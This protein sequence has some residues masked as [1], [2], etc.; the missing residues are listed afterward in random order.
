MSFLSRHKEV[1]RALVFI[2]CYVEGLVLTK[3][4]LVEKVALKNTKLPAKVVETIVD[5]IFNCITNGLVRD[6]RVEIR[7][8]GSF[9]IK[10]RMAREARNPK[11]GE[12]VMVPG[13]RI[14]AFRA[15]KELRDRVDK[16][17]NV[18]PNQSES[19]QL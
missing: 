11:T 5:T 17:R 13:K 18:A 10:K 3:S 9:S 7:G 19:F 2:N 8:L 14:P 4:E 6:E 16:G 1:P 15:G 12:K